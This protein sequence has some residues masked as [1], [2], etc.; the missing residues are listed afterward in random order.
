MK[1]QPVNIQD[2]FLNQL[3]KENMPVTV[4]LLNGFQLRGHVK[5][6]DNFTV[7]L[8][9][10]GKQQLIYKHAISTFSPQRNVQLY[11]DKTQPANDAD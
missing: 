11:Q 2:Q 1:Q 4:F 3:R 5:S 6:F 8:E 10:D 9:T 7:I